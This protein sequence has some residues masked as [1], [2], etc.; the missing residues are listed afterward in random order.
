MFRSHTKVA[1]ELKDG[2]RFDDLEAQVLA[3]GLRVL[4]EVEWEEW[5]LREDSL[6]VA[7]LEA[8]ENA[9]R[10]CLREW[11]LESTPPRDW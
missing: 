10:K 2:I 3:S 7:M 1:A 11:E 6:H 8:E 4:E 9:A 5:L